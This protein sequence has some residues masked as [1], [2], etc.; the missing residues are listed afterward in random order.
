M[1]V[2]RENGR[3]AAAPLGALEARARLYCLDWPRIA[4]RFGFDPEVA[5]QHEA[6]I[7]AMQLAAVLEHVAELT[8]N[9]AHIIDEMSQLG[10]GSFSILDYVSACAPTIRAG[11]QNWVRFHAVFAR[12]IDIEFRVGAGTGVLEYA[13]LAPLGTHVQLSYGI[14]A[15]VSARLFA[16]SERLRDAIRVEVDAPAPQHACAFLARHGHLFS[17]GHDRIRIVIPE[18]VLDDVPVAAEE[19]LYRIVE[20]AALA[21]L[22]DLQREESPLARITESINQHLKAG[23]LSVGSVAGDLNMSERTLQRLLQDEGTTFRKLTEDTRRSL[24]ERYLKETRLPIKE[25]TYLLGFSEVSVFSRAAKSWFGL[26]P[27]RIRQGG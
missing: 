26:S 18:A 15:S 5:R 16:W 24:A 10:V 17:F 12:G 23:T 1:A 19:N 4:E 14:A 13:S 3:V 27:K 11:L 6:T 22:A 2:G 7:S 21:K 9:D 20:T 8:G 25:I